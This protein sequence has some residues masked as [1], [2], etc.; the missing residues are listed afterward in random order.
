MAGAT[1]VLLAAAPWVLRRRGDGDQGPGVDG[2][3]LRA[4]RVLL[5][6]DRAQPA[7]GRPVPRARAWCSSTTSTRC[8]PARRSCSRPTARRPRSS[9]RREPTGRF[10][11]ERGV[12]A[13]HQGPPRG[14]GAGRQG[15]HRPLRRPRGPRRGGRHA[16]GGPRRHPPGRA[17]GRRRRG[18]ARGRR[19]ARSRC[20]P[21]PRSS[22]D[23]WEGDHGPRP[24]ALPRAVDRGRSDLCFAT[25][26][27]QAALQAIAARADAIVVIG[28]ANSSNTLALAK[29]ATAAG[30]P[31][32]LR[33]DGPDELARRPGRRARRRRHRRRERAR[34]AGAGG[35]RPPRSDATASSRCTSPTRTSTSRRRGSSAS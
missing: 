16:G 10:V 22:I 27:R 28:S 19:P 34:G 1:K 5:P 20:S 29:V 14:Q 31:T 23:D 3:G 25:T 13:R 35:H 24:G 17:R 26:N 11:V 7:G 30:C 18:A 32:V 15:L 33:I 2:P 6:R 12:P 4:A 21:R 9:P 8:P